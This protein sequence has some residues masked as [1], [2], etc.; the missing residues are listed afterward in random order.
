M[1][2]PT[3][4]VQKLCDSC[5]LGFAGGDDGLSHGDCVEP[6]TF[7]LFRKLSGETRPTRL[8]PLASKPS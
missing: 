1:S 4:L 2:P 7:L 5:I 8:A 3:A 6:L